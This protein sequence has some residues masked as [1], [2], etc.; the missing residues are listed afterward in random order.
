MNLRIIRY[1]LRELGNHCV[2]PGLRIVLL[3]M[4]GIIIGDGAFVNMGVRYI[5]NY[6]G[7][8]IVLGNR[9]SIAPAVL[10]IAD[11]DPNS[12]HLNKIKS[13]Y[14]RGEIIIGDDAWVGAGA[15]IL[16]NIRIGKCAIIGAGAVITKNIDDYC[17]MAGNPARKIGDVRT[18]KGWKISN[19]L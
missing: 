15:V 14:I 5:D 6:R 17:I 8:A 19:T 2:V 12:S 9:V 18:H 3:R 16:P 10:F 11:A 4:S 13:L 7:K 1:L